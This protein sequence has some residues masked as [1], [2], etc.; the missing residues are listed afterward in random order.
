MEGDASFVERTVR[1]A[2]ALVVGHFLMALES[3]PSCSATRPC[4]G[5][6]RRRV[7]REQLAASVQEVLRAAVDG[8]LREFRRFTDKRNTA[9][10]LEITEKEREVQQ[11]TERL[12]TVEGELRLA[13][14]RLDSARASPPRSRPANVGEK[15]LEGEVRDTCLEGLQLRRDSVPSSLGRSHPRREGLVDR[16]SSV[17]GE[18]GDAPF[19]TENDSYIKLICVKEEVQHQEICMSDTGTP[20]VGIYDKEE[21]EDDDDD[22]SCGS[23]DKILVHIKEEDSNQ[24]SI[25]SHTVDS[26]VESVHNLNNDYSV[27]NALSVNT[28]QCGFHRRGGTASHLLAVNTEQ[29]T[30]ALCCPQEDSENSKDGD[31]P[32]AFV[33]RMV[34]T[35]SREYAAHFSSH[36]KPDNEDWPSRQG[37]VRDS[38]QHSAVTS[39]DAAE[40][41]QWIEYIVTESGSD[42]NESGAVENPRRVDAGKR[43]YSCD[44]C[45]KCFRWR[46]D[47][48]K[49]KK[50]HTGE[51]P[52]PCS[53]CG[54]HFRWKGDVQKHKKIHTGEKP[55]ACDECGKR[56]IKRNHLIRHLKT[57][58]ADKPYTCAQCGDMFR[59][60]LSFHKHQKMHVVERPSCCLACGMK[61]LNKQDFLIHQQSHSGDK[62]HP[63]PECGKRFKWKSDVKKHL[64]VHT[65]ERPYVCSECCKAFTKKS[66]LNRHMF[67]HSEIKP[68]T[69]NECGSRF[70]GKVTFEK[71]KKTHL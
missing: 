3:E 21:D 30:S 50:I 35:D 68:Y 9:L 40:S 66:H 38:K 17:N 45:G 64:K 36:S 7:L 13:R 27:L 53:E 51:K 22:D 61:F 39:G 48:Q 58:T 31:G 6:D 37:S 19:T 12:E 52:Y 24:E 70:K 28:A 23:F 44:V 41:C 63:C 4:F 16:T 25:P 2:A 8:V 20:N 57:H 43:P 29:V 62:L 14:R 59:W 55:H 5:D 49:H 42:L 47:V 54:K 65:G 67:I 33:S 15:K 1:E 69:C 56:F 10:C 18:E 34:Q 32:S 71:H 11:L 60:K 46:G 26:E